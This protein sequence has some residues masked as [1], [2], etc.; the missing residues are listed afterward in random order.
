MGRLDALAG[1]H[2]SNAALSAVLQH[3]NEEK[4]EKEAA[5]V[6]LASERARKR[7]ESDH[8]RFFV[9]LTAASDAGDR[10][11][12]DALR[13]LTAAKG[14]AE[15]QAARLVRIEGT[16]GQALRRCQRQRA[17][18]PLAVRRQFARERRASR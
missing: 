13:G 15:C 18:R 14:L 4:K 10:A 12:A 1:A 11:V 5:S 2:V 16:S 8:Q 7:A 17:A 6:E 9:S 3:R